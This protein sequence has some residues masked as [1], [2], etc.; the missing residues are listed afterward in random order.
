MRKKILEKLVLAKNMIQLSRTVLMECR[1]KDMEFVMNTAVILM[2]MSKH[3][4]MAG[5]GMM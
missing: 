5:I 1:V 3:I 2:V 4:M